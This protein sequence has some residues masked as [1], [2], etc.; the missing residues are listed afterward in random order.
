MRS[1]WGSSSTRSW[2]RFLILILIVPTVRD[3]LWTIAKDELDLFQNQNLIFKK[4]NQ[5]LKTVQ[6]KYLDY[7][8]HKPIQSKPNLV[9]LSQTNPNLI[10][11]KPIQTLGKKKEFQTMADENFESNRA[12]VTKYKI[13]CDVQCSVEGFRFVDLYFIWMGC[14]Q[15]TGNTCWRSF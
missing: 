1:W 13:S 12:L 3:K 2:Y 14:P 4:C 11:P 15:V 5:V 7:F 8:Y 10:Y 6:H 9:L